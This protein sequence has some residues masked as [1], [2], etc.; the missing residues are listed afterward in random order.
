LPGVRR[1]R[2]RFVVA[3]V[4]L[5]LVP[6]AF[7]VPAATTSSLVA[8]ASPTETRVSFRSGP[9]TLSGILSLPAGRERH[10]AVVLLSGSERGGT[11]SP[12]LVEH[13]RVLTG[14]GFAVLRYDPPGVGRSTRSLRLETLDDRAR[15]AIAAVDYLRS[16]PEI[17]PD[18]I[19][20]WGGSQG[21]WVT[22][23]AAAASKSVAFLVS[24]SGS[25]VSPAEQQVY[26]TVASSRAAGFPTLAVAKAGLF[27]RLLVDWQLTRPVYREQNL[28][29]VRRLGA[30]PWSTFATLV[31]TPGSLTPAQGLQRGIAVLRSIR[32]EPWARY[33]YLDTAVLPA[34]EAIPA[35][36][37]AAVRAAAEKSLLVSPKTYLT[38]VHCPVLAIW[39]EDDTVV[40][41]RRSASLYRQYL[42][43]ARNHDVTIVFFANAGH[44]LKNAPDYWKTLTGWLKHR[45]DT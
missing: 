13:A 4:V 40:P 3:T 35:G 11:R 18:E 25:G 7:A 20:L 42:K 15:E 10:A 33:L 30:G 31:Y 36:Q 28:A 12:Y 37:V 34:L 32:T 6:A 2:S 41:A 1:E 21:G 26:T 45:F 29:E 17:R 43:A 38:A 44:E 19:G 39:G 9:N 16:R 22:Q 27:A 14:S 23:M 24:V 8:S 5:L